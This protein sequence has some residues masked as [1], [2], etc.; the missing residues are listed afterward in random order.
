VNENE[1]VIEM[2]GIDTM[3]EERISY[4]LLTSNMS[5]STT[6]IP[7]DIPMELKSTHKTLTNDIHVNYT[8][9]NGSESMTCK[10]EDKL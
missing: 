5:V 3:K 6:E 9:T 10:L 1:K 7:K 2:N 8:Q 4:D